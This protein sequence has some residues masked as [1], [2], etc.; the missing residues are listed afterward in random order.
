MEFLK[1]S[2]DLTILVVLG[3]MGF[4]ALLFTLERVI[5]L[6]RAQRQLQHYPSV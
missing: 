3:G 2:I 5:F 6:H 4:L 1:H